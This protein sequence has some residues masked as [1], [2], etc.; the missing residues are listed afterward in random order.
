[1]KGARAELAALALALV[2]TGCAS[3]PARAP[4]AAPAAAPAHP[5]ASFAFAVETDVPL[6]PL[7]AY[8]AFAN[9]L[10]R[11]WDHTFSGDPAAFYLEARPGGGFYELFDEGGDGVLHATVTW[12]ERGKRLVFRGP[13]GLH[14]KAVDLVSDVSF[15]PAAGGTRVR[16]DVHVAGE[17]EPESAPLIESVWRHFLVERYAL[18]ARGEL[19]ER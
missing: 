11:W 1:M 16:V 19:G 15:A 17:V 18:Y 13:L 4:A 6:D 3:A 12:A 14:G 8:D 9:D 7:A 10:G 2:A 5:L